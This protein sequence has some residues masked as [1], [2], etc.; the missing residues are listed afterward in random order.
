MNTW[1]PDQY[2]RFRA[3]RSQPFFDLLEMV[4]PRPGMEAI[5]LGCGSGELTRLLHQRLAAQR[6]LGIDNSETMLARSNDYP[7]EG[8]RFEVGDIRT[9]LASGAP[10]LLFSNAAL[11]WVENHPALFAGLAEALRPGGQLAVQMPANQDHPSHAI[12]RQIAREAPWVEA[13]EG[14]EGHRN[15]LAPAAYAELLHGLGF[16]KQVVTLRVYAHLLPTTADVVEWTKGT[17]LTGYKARLPENLYGA[18]E[19]EYRERVLAHFGMQSPFFYPFPRILL[20][21]EKPGA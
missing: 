14:Y 13:L 6:T 4:H 17:L 9:F 1:D 11:Q 5:D 19:A 16:A 7:A 21:A 10:D 2:E 15:V 20:W 8:L 18:F 3:E 12:A